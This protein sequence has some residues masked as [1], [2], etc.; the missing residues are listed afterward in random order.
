M[1]TPEAVRL[2][3]VRRLA[4]AGCVAADAEADELLSRAPDEATLDAWLARREEGEPLSWITGFQTFCGHLVAVDR[5]VYVPRPQSEALACRAATFLEASPRRRAA[6]LCTGSGA[7]ARHLQTVAG[8][9]VAGV[10]LDIDAVRCAR[11]NGVPAVV[12]DLGASLGTATVDVVTAVAPY[13]PTA[14]MEFL[15]R[16][17]RDHEPILTLDG[18]DDGLTVVRRLVEDAPRLLQPGGWL[19][20]E[21]GGDQDRHLAGSVVA[22]GFG[23]LTTWH[24]EEGDLRGMSAQRRG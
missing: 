5:G 9:Q 1:R 22:A 8:A 2:D 13:V 20:V 16:D 18:G 19:L 21:L 7:V 6:D 11:R 24:D 14:E 12:G 23:N 3:L 4:M 17:V 15:P 10:D